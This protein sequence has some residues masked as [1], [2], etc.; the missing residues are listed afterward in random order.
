MQKRDH[1]VTNILVHNLVNL[2]SS[3]NTKAEHF[4]TT[5]GTGNFKSAQLRDCSQQLFEQLKAFAGGDESLLKAD[6]MVSA[7]ESPLDRMVWKLMLM[8]L[9]MNKNYA[10]WSVNQVAFGLKNV[11]PETT[12]EEVAEA[13]IRLDALQCVKKHDNNKL[14]VALKN[15][16]YQHEL[17]FVDKTQ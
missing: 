1:N 4:D 5:I 6:W 7:F 3:W 9:D 14:W 17:L 15:D 11:R 16:K 8:A 12:S 10:P 13:L 2:V